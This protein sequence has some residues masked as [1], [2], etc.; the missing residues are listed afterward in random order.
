MKKYVI[1]KIVSNNIEVKYAYVG[2]TKNFDVRKRAHKSDS[3][4]EI[5]AHMKIYKFINEHGGW[6][7][8]T[9]VKI[10]TCLCESKDEARELEQKYYKELN[11]SLNTNRP[12]RTPEELKED[13]AKYNKQYKIDNKIAIKEQNKQ[14]RNKD[15]IKQYHEQNKEKMKEY[16]LHNKD[17]IKQYQSQYYHQNKEKLKE[18]Q[19]QYKLQNNDKFIQYYEK[20]K[21]N[22]KEYQR[23][24]QLQNKDKI[25]QYHEQNKVRCDACKYECIKHNMIKHL[26]SKKHLKNI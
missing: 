8:W 19:R 13:K 10:E 12:M 3:K 5:K 6:A 24:Y 20:N 18:Y 15:K 17:N 7:C 26:K 23:Q 22:L 2:H 1:Y 21:E 14:Y 9:M 11:E 25:K 4:R 16:Q